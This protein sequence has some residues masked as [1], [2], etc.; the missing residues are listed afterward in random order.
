MSILGVQFTS[1]AV[2]TLAVI[3]FIGLFAFCYYLGEGHD[4]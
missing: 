3:A 2:M 1:G 4:A